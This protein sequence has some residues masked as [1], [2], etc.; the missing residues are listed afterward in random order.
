MA[1]NWLGIGIPALVL[2]V[3]ALV[4]TLCCFVGA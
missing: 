1:L 3:V 4:A 2:G